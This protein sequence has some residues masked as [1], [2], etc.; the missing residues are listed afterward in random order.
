MIRLRKKSANPFTA[1]QFRID[2]PNAISFSTHSTCELN[3][4]LIKAIVCLTSCQ[5]SINQ[6]ATG[7]VIRVLLRAL[8]V[9]VGEGR[10]FR[11]STSVS[12]AGFALSRS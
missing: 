3:F 2:K 6:V 9:Y 5:H 8:V 12:I 1:S 4:K 11:R 10:R 7:R